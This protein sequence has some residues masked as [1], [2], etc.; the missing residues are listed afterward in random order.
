M[1]RRPRPLRRRAALTEILEQRRLLSADRVFELLPPVQVQAN[2]VNACVDCGPQWQSKNL[3]DTP[4][5]A[6]LDVLFDHDHDHD[7]TITTT[8]ITITITIT[9]TTTTTTMK[10]M[11]SPYP[12]THWQKALS[13]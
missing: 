1:V 12:M 11:D 6:W 2:P 9:T 13:I 3:A 4:N 7:D 10:T 5:W 8:T